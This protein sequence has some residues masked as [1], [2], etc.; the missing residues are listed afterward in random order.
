M[1]QSTHDSGH[2]KVGLHQHPFI[3][4]AFGAGLQIGRCSLCTP[5]P[6]IRQGNRLALKSLHHRQKLLIVDIG[7]IPSPCDHFGSI[8]DQSTQPDS[9][10]PAVIG[11]PFAANLGWATP[12]APRVDQL[13]AIGVDNYKESGVGQEDVRPRL[14]SMKQAQQFGKSP[15]AAGL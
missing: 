3:P 14:V 12:F 6:Q 11:Q 5:K 9:H 4:R 8:I 13:H 1:L 7:G 10:D 2:R 15:G